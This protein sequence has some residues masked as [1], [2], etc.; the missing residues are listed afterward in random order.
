MQEADSKGDLVLAEAIFNSEKKKEFLRREEFF[1]NLFIKKFK[2]I[3]NN[4]L[5][6]DIEGK[7]I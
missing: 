3:I 5:I 2:L 1:Y 4:K 6:L 7:F